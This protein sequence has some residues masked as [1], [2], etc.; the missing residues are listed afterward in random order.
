MKEE[1]WKIVPSNPLV[2]A[3]SGGRLRKA[4]CG[5]VLNQYRLSNA[6]PYLQAKCG[7]R[8]ILVHRYVIEAFLGPSALECN[9]INGVK[10]DNR[11]E[12]LE[13]VTHKGNVQHAYDTGLSEQVRRAAS[14]TWKRMHADKQ[15]NYAKGSGHPLAKIDE[16][17][18]RKIRASSAT[19]TE[20]ALE[21]GMSAHTIRDIRRRK[22]W[23]HV[24]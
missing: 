23:R 9:H 17:A 2:E 14:K 20:V 15:I 3:S 13:Y 16:E 5:K 21:Y 19:N 12:N 7:G 22:T 4:G 6:N 11:I 18:V 24:A 8:R 1:Q 10:G